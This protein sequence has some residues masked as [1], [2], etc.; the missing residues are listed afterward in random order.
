MRRIWP[1]SPAN[2][3]RAPDPVSGSGYPLPEDD[4]PVRGRAATS[5]FLDLRWGAATAPSEGEARLSGIPAA[6]M[7]DGSSARPLAVLAGRWAAGVTVGRI[8]RDELPG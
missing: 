5:R 3:A 8:A 1:G 2:G 6:A 4:P 7:E